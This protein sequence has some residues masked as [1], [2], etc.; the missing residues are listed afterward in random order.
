MRSVILTSINEWNKDQKY[1]FPI[2]QDIQR[3]GALHEAVRAQN[4]IGWDQF[5]CGYIAK[6][7]QYCHLRH[8]HDGLMNDFESNK[9]MIL[10]IKAVFEHIEQQW[11]KWNQAIHGHDDASQRTAERQHLLHTIRALYSLKDQL[12]PLNQRLLHWQEE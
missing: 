8:R 10:T 1:T 6:S 7:F 3:D 12:E 5:L 4:K 2:T 11:E 9:G